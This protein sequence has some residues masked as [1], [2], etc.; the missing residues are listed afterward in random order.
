MK[1]GASVKVVA[2]KLHSSLQVLVDESKVEWLAK[3]FEANQVT[4]SYLVIAATDDNAL[5]Q[6]VFDAAESQQRLVNV[7]DDQ[8]RCSYIFPSI[9]DRS[10][11][12]I[13]ISSGGAAPVLIRL[14]REN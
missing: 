3:A 5:N 12:Q 4:S 11:V 7:V 1:A 14:L 10:P 2:E 9:I 13:A 6:Q 8:P